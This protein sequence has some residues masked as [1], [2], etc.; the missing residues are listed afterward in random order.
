MI[1]FMAQQI[2]VL[3]NS[4]QNASKQAD[5]SNINNTGNFEDDFCPK[6]HVMG[7]LP[8]SLLSKMRKK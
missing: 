3:R 4:E 5:A 7:D 8:V 1:K 6:F 2:E